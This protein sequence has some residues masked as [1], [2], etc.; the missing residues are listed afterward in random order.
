MSS[1]TLHQIHNESLD[2]E[3]VEIRQ[4]SSITRANLGDQRA[5]DVFVTHSLDSMVIVNEKGELFK[6]QFDQPLDVYGINSLEDRNLII[7][8][9]QY[10]S[11][12]AH[13]N[14]ETDGRGLWRLSNNNSEHTCLLVSDRAL[15]NVDLRVCVN[16]DFV[17]HFEL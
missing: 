15:F 11:I 10:H 12:K 4:L 1:L 16:L 9:T 5:T 13:E 17:N 7:R 14:D 6:G 8:L 2:R 3:S